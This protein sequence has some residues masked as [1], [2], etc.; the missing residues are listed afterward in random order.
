MWCAQR[1]IGIEQTANN[2]LVE[3]FAMPDFPRSILEFQRQFPDEAAC[4]AW[5]TAARWPEGFRCPVCGHDHAWEL[6]TKAWTWECAKCHRQTSVTAGTVMHGSKVSLT[7]W[8]WAAYLMATH[9][10]GIS[11]RQLGRQLGLGSY[12]AIAHLLILGGV[13]IGPDLASLRKFDSGI[14]G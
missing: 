9:S 12:N 1:R 13:G 14:S 4:A 5:L 3:A 8:F 2:Y 6:D 11:A 10:N 7:V